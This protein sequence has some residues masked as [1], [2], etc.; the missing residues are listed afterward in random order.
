MNHN[1]QMQKETGKISHRKIFVRKYRL[2]IDS[3]CFPA[4]DVYSIQFISASGRICLLSNKHISDTLGDHFVYAVLG[5][6]EENRA[7]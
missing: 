6:P 3:S 7:I 1:M 2:I 4:P 5:I